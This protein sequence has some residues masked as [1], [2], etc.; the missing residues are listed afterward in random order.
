MLPIIQ[1]AFT[2][3]HY[4]LVKQAYLVYIRE[5]PGNFVDILAVLHY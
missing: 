1:K 3:Q 2:T 5:K 4:S